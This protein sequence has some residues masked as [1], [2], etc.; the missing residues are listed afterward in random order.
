[1]RATHSNRL[2]TLPP[3]I[4]SAVNKTERR[5]TSQCS[6]VHSPECFAMKNDSSAVCER[7]RGNNARDKLQRIAKFYDATSNIVSNIAFLG[8]R[9]KKW[10]KFK[11]ACSPFS[12][13][14]IDCCCRRVIWA[15][16]P[17]FSHLFVCRES[18]TVLLHVLAAAQESFSVSHP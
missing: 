4:F 16:L 9:R 3:N 14:C 6:L 13:V 2:S 18:T 15:W 5:K 10:N 8:I 12:W 1:M 11:I 17:P 7:E